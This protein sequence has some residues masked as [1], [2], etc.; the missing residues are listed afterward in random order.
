MRACR[1]FGFPWQLSTTVRRE[2]TD[3]LDLGKF[4]NFMFQIGLGLPWALFK[5]ELFLKT[6]RPCR[7]SFEHADVDSLSRVF[8]AWIQKLDWQCRVQV[9][10]PQQ[11]PGDSAFFC[12][13][14]WWPHQDYLDDDRGGNGEGTGVW[15]G[16]ASG[17]A[18]GYGS[19][20]L[21]ADSL[22]LWAL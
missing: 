17:Q 13:R 2:R 10:P 19:F 3:V 16:T 20:Q 7:F 4:W 8:A 21:C 18:L 6:L 22:L 5:I 1:S 12:R 14:H 15:S 9:S 11:H